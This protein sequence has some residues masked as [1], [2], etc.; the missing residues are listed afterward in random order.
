MSKIRTQIRE[1]QLAGATAA[2]I[3]DEGP[4]GTAL[5]MR[6][7]PKSDATTRVLQKSEPLIYITPT[8][9]ETSACPGA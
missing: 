3:K 6:S 1:F 4:S 9:P 2:R 7:E 8:N 5:S